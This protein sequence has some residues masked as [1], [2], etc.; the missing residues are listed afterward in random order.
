MQPDE[1]KSFFKDVGSQVKVTPKNARWA[2]VR[3]AMIKSI[4]HYKKEQQLDRVQR[5]Y[6]PLGVLEK[7]G[8]MWTP[9]CDMETSASMKSLS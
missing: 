6:L 5:K 8:M 4:T 7:K 9:S 2:L 3:A 1:Q